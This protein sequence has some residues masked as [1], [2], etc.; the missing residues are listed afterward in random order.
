MNSSPN[1]PAR[2]LVLVLVCTWI[3]LGNGKA[4]AQNYC[5]NP[6]PGTGTGS[7]TLSR[8]RTCANLPIT[9]TNTLAGAQNITYNYQYSGN[10]LPVTNLTPNTSTSYTAPGTFTILQVGTSSATG[11]AKCETVTIMPTEAIT[12]TTQS[13]DNRQVTASF[14]FTPNTEQ[15]DE[16]E[17]DWGDG[18]LQ[19]F[20]VATLKAGPASHQY[21]NTTQRQISV[22]GKYNSIADCNALRAS[23]SVTPSASTGGVPF[24]SQITTLNDASV[25]MRIQGPT[26]TSFAV[27][28]KQPDGTFRTLS[29]VE[30]DGSTPI[31]GV[32]TTT[33]QCF[34]VRSV[35]S[36]TPTTSNEEYCTVVLD[37]KAAPGQNNL[38]WTPYTGASP[39][40]FWR[41]LRNGAAVGIPGNTNKNTKAYTD[42]NDIRC[43]T[44]Y[45]YR[46]TAEAGRTTIVSNAICVTG[47]SSNQPNALSNV[48]V[49][50]QGNGVDIRTIDPNPTGSG[51]YTLIV[52]RAD[53]PSG[54]FNEI[55]QATNQA[56]FTDPSARTSDQSYCYRIVLRNECGQLSPPS[57][58]ACTVHLMSKSPGALDWT[59]DSP[60]SGKP[61][62]EYEVVF[63][64][65][66][67]GVE[68]NRQSVGG[69]THFEPDRND[70]DLPTYRFEI[71]AVSATNQ[72]SRS[73]PYELQVEAGIFAPTAF[74]PNGFTN[75][76]QVKGDFTDD[77]RLTIFNRWGS[78]VY[79]TTSSKD[80]DGWDGN[81]DGQPAPAG[82]YAWR[83]ETRDKAGKQTV[84]ASSVLLIR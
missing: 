43:N 5:V 82:T 1:R 46:L 53:G 60:F 6:P 74:A 71:V 4:L 68:I 12:F 81:A 72:S 57:E 38:S 33:P 75:R 9:V 45:C 80:V 2:W 44:Q 59:A 40:I 25:Q 70:P 14:Q 27:L 28:V 67:S 54:T 32:V 41:L 7:F 61:V 55:G 8:T 16:I 63:I 50:V 84:K 42:Q 56:T 36:C 15:Y 64:D 62:R 24:I 37:A 79:S 77:F 26:N 73:N 21:A 30:K 22:R 49:S 58:P 34:Q 69:N 29:E 78:V 11:F 47:I 20:T 66:D 52:T 31:F 18:T 83:V 13:C 19:V 39:T 17:V 48:T 23:Q 65:R 51:N 76:F 35:S 3:I 10:G